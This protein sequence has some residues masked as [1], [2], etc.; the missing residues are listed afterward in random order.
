MA[1][2]FECN[3][4]PR[5]M[6]T[7]GGKKFCE[8]CRKDVYDVRR[9]SVEHIVAL[10]Q[11]LGECCVII[12]DDQLSKAESLLNAKRPRP[13]HKS[14][15][16]PYAAGIAALSL[17]PFSALPH[18]AKPASVLSEQKNGEGEIVASQIRHNDLTTAK[19]EFS[20]TIRKSPKKLFKKHII[21]MGY[22]GKNK[23][24]V[25]DFIV[26]K[27]FTSHANGK[28]KFSLTRDEMTELQGKEVQ[29]KSGYLTVHYSE[30][31]LFN[32]GHSFF[33]D[34]FKRIMWRGKF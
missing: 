6:K 11:R 30:F 25:Y 27:T 29:F 4:D 23:D 33:I 3:Q 18:V 19:L 10:K 26:V 22:Y 1:L 15:S 31:D 21:E 16:F 28:F 34:I 2:K 32:P 24:S 20:G 17:V 14:F 12:Y 8:V 7:I 13:P 9:K 5:K